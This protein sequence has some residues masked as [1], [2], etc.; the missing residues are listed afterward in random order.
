MAKVSFYEKLGLEKYNDPA[1][2]YGKKYVGKVY[3]YRACFVLTDV[4]VCCELLFTCFIFFISLKQ[5]FMHLAD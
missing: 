5:Y 2:Q 1:V 3:C 4:G